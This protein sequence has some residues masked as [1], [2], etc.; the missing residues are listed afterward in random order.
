VNEALNE[1]AST[2]HK[3]P[4]KD[5]CKCHKKDPCSTLFKDN[6]LLLII[7][8]VVLICCCSP[9]KFG[10]A[11][12]CCKPK[13]GCKPTGGIGGSWVW[14]LLLLLCCCGGGLGGAGILG[15]GAGNVNTNVI[16]VDTTEDFVDEYTDCL[17]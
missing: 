11:H 1:V 17:C 4:Y 3:D 9:G 10:G 15:P 13:K 14:I 5:P 8:A 7:V 2:Y 16:K 12:S 6:N